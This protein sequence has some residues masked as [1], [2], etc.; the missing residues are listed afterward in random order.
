MFGM[1]GNWGPAG[2]FA[3]VGNVL[4]GDTTGGDAGTFENVSVGDVRDGTFWGEDGTELEGT[5]AVT[6]APP[7]I[8]FLRRR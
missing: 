6:G 4:E 1:F 3:D 5:L 7:S 2:D 8:F